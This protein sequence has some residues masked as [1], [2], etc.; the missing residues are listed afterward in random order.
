MLVHKRVDNLFVNLSGT[1]IIR[2]YYRLK[3]SKTML[4]AVFFNRRRFPRLSVL[5]KQEEIIM[6]KNVIS[7]ILCISMAASLLFGC[8]SKTS[9]EGSD[10]EAAYTIGITQF[11][12][13][14]SLD[15]CR[16]GFIE[17]LKA[18]GLEEG[19]NLKIEFQNAQADS[20]AASQIASQFVSDKVDLICAIAT[21]SAQSCINAA[22]DSDIPVIYTAVTDPVAAEIADENKM[23]TKNATGT[24]DKLPIEAQLDLIRKI[25]PDAK[26]I[27]ILYTT[28]EVNSESA[29]K[30]YKEKAGEYG[31]EIVDVGISTT[32][33]ITLATDNI[34]TKVDCLT[35]LTDNTVVQGLPTILAKANEKG[36]PVFG[37]E[38][39]Q[40]KKGCLAAAGLD[41]I[42]L[43][44]KTGEM[45]AKVLKGEAKAD[46]MAYETF[47]TY[48]TYFNQKA[49]EKLSLTIDEDIIKKAEIFTEITE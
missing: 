46:E 47:E 35:N 15:N 11:A 44:K 27:G 19:K 48:S 1:A 23:P 14:G 45:A 13:H 4:G 16:E 12:E 28:S 26:S 5:P 17:G 39:E 30:E 43:G 42:E 32:A 31:F 9:Q 10:G 7:S 25:L 6:K 34:L 3:Y 37:S 18:A 20:G 2:F 41:Y 8:G 29:I 24:S 22:L 49:A 33:D 40:V 36:I 21:P 38:I